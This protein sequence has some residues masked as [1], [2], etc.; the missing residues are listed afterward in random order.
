MQPI[1]LY[2]DGMCLLHR[3][4]S[5]FCAGDHYVAFNFFRGLKAI[6][7]KF[8]PSRV[9]L[10]LEGSSAYRKQLDS[11]YKSNRNTD[12][13]DSASVSFYSQV[14][15]TINL[16]SE[17]F[18][19]SV[20]SH[21]ELEADDVIARMVRRSS[22]AVKCVII[23]SDRDY[24]QLRSEIGESVEIYDPIKKDFLFV[25]PG[26]GS[27]LIYR[28]LKGDS[29]DCIPRLT[30]D[31]TAIQLSDDN[32]ALQEFLCLL[33]EEKLSRFELNLKLLQFAEPADGED[34]WLKMR[35]SSPKRDWDAVM[36]WFTM[37][38]FKSITKDIAKFIAPFERL[39]QA[40]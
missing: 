40:Q 26:V 2:I 13:H 20:V 4:A 14:N 28:A 25:P 18:P 17:N 29:S 16:I 31:A 38:D 9:V 32:D 22:R 5:G 39:W 11:A 27:F 36:L 8:S 12:K 21:P 24:L 10:A 23:S 34:G 37:W 6:I 3:A 19:I 15:E 30:D 1:T 7:E 33:P 35:S